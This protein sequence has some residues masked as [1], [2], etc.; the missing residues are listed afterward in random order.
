[1]TAPTLARPT[2]R[3]GLRLV[4]FPGAGTTRYR[5]WEHYLPAGAQVMTTDPADRADL[6]VDALV[7]H[8]NAPLAFF[9]YGDGASMAHEVA[10]RLGA[11]HGVHPT[12]LF[13]SCCAAPLRATRLTS[14]IVAY[15]GDRNPMC[16]VEDV[17]RWAEATTARFE[18]RVFPSLEPAESDVLR[19]VVDDLGRQQMF[20]RGS[21]V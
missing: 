14:P 17:R 10:G 5:S 6:I 20:R 8:L 21:N 16:A 9:G 15:V 18:L 13:V 11:E 19:H 3:S 4:C 7:P 1:M 12:R 2:T